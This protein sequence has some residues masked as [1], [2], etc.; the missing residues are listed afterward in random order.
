MQVQ[1]R[2]RRIQARAAPNVGRRHREER[3]GSGS[4]AAARLGDPHVHLAETGENLALGQA[5]VAHHPLAPVGE[6]LVTER[7]QVLLELRPDRSLDQPPRPGAHK[8]REGVGNRC[9]RRQRNHSI[10]A[11]V[12]CAPLAETVVSSDLISTKTRRTSQPI[13][14]PLS[15]IARMAIS[16]QVHDPPPTGAGSAALRPETRRGRTATGGGIRSDV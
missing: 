1:P 8:L 7:R 16:R 2:D 14:T 4:R 13:R 5:P 3:N 12:R 10:V 11:H 15:T 9:W 6:L